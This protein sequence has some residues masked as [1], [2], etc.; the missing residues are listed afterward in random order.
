[1][2][3]KKCTPESISLELALHTLDTM[4]KRLIR[5]NHVFMSPGWAE[6]QDQYDLRVLQLAAQAIRKMEENNEHEQAR[7]C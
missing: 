6:L 2:K 3:E 7:L 5:A 1:M 4:R